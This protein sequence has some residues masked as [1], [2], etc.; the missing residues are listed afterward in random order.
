[1]CALTCAMC[2]QVLT[3]GKQVS[4]SPGPRLISNCGFF[5]TNWGPLEEEESGRAEVL[6]TTVISLNSKAYFYLCVSVCLCTC[7]WTCQLMLLEDIRWPGIKLQAVVSNPA[8]VLKPILGA[9]GEHQVLLTTELSL[10]TPTS[11]KFK[12]ERQKWKCLLWF[13]LS[14]AFYF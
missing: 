12:N 5:L 14:K 4:N 10:H 1:M 9:L 7:V 2:V 8:S 3:K 11:Y 13:W 6:L